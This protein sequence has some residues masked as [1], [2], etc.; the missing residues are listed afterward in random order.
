MA[1]NDFLLKQRAMLRGFFEAGLNC[2]RQQ[3]IDMVALVLRDNEIMGKDTFGKDRLSKIVQGINDYLDEYS[4]AWQKDDDTDVWQKRLD[5]ALAEAYGPELADS[6]YERYPF[7]PEFD[8][9]K[10]R[11]K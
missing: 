10:G 7:A 8:Y 11:W 6:F 9:T 3:I 1:K 2:G 4:L 5:D